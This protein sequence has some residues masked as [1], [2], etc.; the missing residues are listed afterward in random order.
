MS[1]I[2][3]INMHNEKPNYVKINERCVARSN[4]S[5]IGNPFY[6]ANESQR[7]VVCNKYKVWF[8][9]MIDPTNQSA[10]ARNVMIE[11]RK[12]LHVFKECRVLKLY[13]WCA[14]KACHAETIRDWLLKNA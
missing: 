12:L 10:E 11:L 9:L 4:G 2:T 3:I 6:M 14:P 1:K 8:G 5:A 7:D 13:C